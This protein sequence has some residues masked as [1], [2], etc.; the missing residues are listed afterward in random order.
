MQQ[1]EQRRQAR[2]ESRQTKELLKDNEL[3]EK[4]RKHEQYLLYQ[5]NKQ[6]NSA[7]SYKMP[8]AQ[9][10]FVP[11]Y[12]LTHTGEVARETLSIPPLPEKKLKFKKMT[13][14]DIANKVPVQS[15]D[16]DEEEEDNNMNISNTVDQQ[17]L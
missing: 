3:K 5:M 14:Q 6:L 9:A 7:E 16:R 4:T 12:F 2:R 13:G 8:P 15:S 1:R 11:N 17:E 10:L